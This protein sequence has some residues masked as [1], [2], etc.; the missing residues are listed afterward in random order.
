MTPNVQKYSMHTKFQALISVGGA[1]R[2]LEDL[3]L[4]PYI[5]EVILV[6]IPQN[7]KKKI[8]TCTSCTLNSAQSDKET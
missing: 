3:S 1:N 6:T 8:G 4:I 7:T 2:F 5:T